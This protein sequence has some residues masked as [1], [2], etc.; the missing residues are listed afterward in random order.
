MVEMY[1]QLREEISLWVNRGANFSKCWWS[2]AH[3]GSY[4]EF[5]TSRLGGFLEYAQFLAAGHKFGAKYLVES[6][7]HY[8]LHELLFSSDIRFP[9]LDVGEILFLHMVEEGLPKMGP[10]REILMG[11]KAM[12]PGLYEK[13]S[14]NLN[15]YDALFQRV[16]EPVFDLA[17]AI[18]SSTSLYGPNRRMT[19]E[20]RFKPFP[21]KHQDFS[22][23]KMIIINTGEELE[24]E[25]TAMTNKTGIVAHP[26]LLLVP[27]LGRCGPG[28]DVQR[29]APD[30]VA[31]IV[32]E[33]A[34][35]NGHNLP[36]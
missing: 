33:P 28:E 7:V 15:R 9:G 29:L 30:I 32:D 27:G 3:N 16:L 36:N 26:V 22:I 24:A 19:P 12:M 23:C 6:F 25:R 10:S 14:D 11:I 1:E 34:V 35:M 13:D 21:P 8:L 5:K 2:R 4:V 20:G 17:V 18:K 31:M